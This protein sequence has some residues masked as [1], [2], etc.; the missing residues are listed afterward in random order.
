MSYEWLINSL[1]RGNRR[2]LV[3]YTFPRIP[4]KDEA[5]LP[6]HRLPTPPMRLVE[7][8][9]VSKPSHDSL[10][11]A[12]SSNEND[13]IVIGDSDDE[14]DFAKGYEPAEP[15]SPPFIVAPSPVASEYLPNDEAS[16]SSSET[17]TPDKST[18]SP[19]IGSK[20]KGCAQHNHEAEDDASAEDSEEEW[21]SELIGGHRGTRNSALTAAVKPAKPVKSSKPVKCVTKDAAPVN[22]APPVNPTP[23]KAR[24]LPKSRHSVG[25]QGSPVKTVP[26]PRRAC[27]TLSP[28]PEIPLSLGRKRKTG[29]IGR[30]GQASAR[31][32]VLSPTSFPSASSTDA[33]MDPTSPKKQAAATVLMSL[34][35]AAA[36]SLTASARTEPIISDDAAICNGQV[37]RRAAIMARPI[38]KKSVKPAFDPVQL[39][40]TLVSNQAKEAAVR[41][42]AAAL[43]AA[44]VRANSPTL[45]NE[46]SGSAREDRITG[47][48]PPSKIPVSTTASS[49]TSLQTSTSKTAGTIP[50]R[51][52]S[53]PHHIKP[54]PDPIPSAGRRQ[55]LDA[56]QSRI[57][58]GM[59]GHWSSGNCGS[60]SSV[61]AKSHRP[62]FTLNSAASS[63]APNGSGP[64]SNPL[65]YPTATFRNQH[66][67][68]YDSGTAHGQQRPPLQKRF[69]NADPEFH[70]QQVGHLPTFRDKDRPR[71]QA[72]NGEPPLQPLPTHDAP[73]PPKKR[74][75]DAHEK[76]PRKRPRPSIDA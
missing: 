66:F 46:A 58:G 57:P 44:A 71:W 25:P 6:S 59:H 10:F 26:S 21:F 76:D 72:I 61:A 41:G 52:Q 36:T 49:S 60:G 16:V 35:Q 18:Q 68:S 27:T 75:S 39:V 65:P 53:L 24:Q 64:P 50:G 29:Q 8:A 45:D 11:S 62:A 70:K 31:A 3:N 67:V 73:Q 22:P 28:S 37:G 43:A 19:H 56:G 38:A 54:P 47:L 42:G 48:P 4:S 30:L 74:S 1:L 5:V 23:Q 13:P 33:P 14:N 55:S 69:S 17:S 32:V 9:V 2:Q 12:P 51:R 63:S 7:E 20:D 15:D 40:R 34:G